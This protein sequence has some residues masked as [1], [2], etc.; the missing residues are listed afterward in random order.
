MCSFV[1]LHC[2]VG[3]KMFSSIF[4]IDLFLFLLLLLLRLR[5]RLRLPYGV[6]SLNLSGYGWDSKPVGASPSLNS[7]DPSKLR[8]L[9]RCSTSYR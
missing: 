2:L 3:G 9:I 8:N 1:Y 4:I 6:R 7:V 5:L